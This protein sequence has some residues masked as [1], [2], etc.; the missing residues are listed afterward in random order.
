M[1]LKKQ[2]TSST[3]HQYYENFMILIGLLA[4]LEYIHESYYLDAR[5]IHYGQKPYLKAIE[6]TF[7][8]L[9]AFDWLVELILADR[10]IP[11]LF[12]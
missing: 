2:W 3:F 7:T 8:C 10:T 9:F 12:G 6:L 5:N 4:A 1:Q 11:Y